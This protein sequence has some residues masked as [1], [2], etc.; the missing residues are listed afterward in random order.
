MGCPGPEIQESG[1]AEGKYI[2]YI[3]SDDRI[4][5][6]Y[7]EVL[8]NNAVEYRAQVFCLRVLP[9]MGTRKWAEQKWA[10]QKEGE[11]DFHTLS[12]YRQAGCREDRERKHVRVR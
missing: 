2:T 3:D 10:E 4:G 1:L 7:L 8:Y 5:P 9:G 6:E 11:Q 12:L